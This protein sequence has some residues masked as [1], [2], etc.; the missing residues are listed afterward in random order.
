MLPP[1]RRSMAR[2]RA[3]GTAPP[4]RAAL[5]IGTW[6]Y[7]PDLGT[8]Q[9]GGV[10]HHLEP[11]QAEV[12]SFL[13]AEPGAMRSKTEIMDAVWGDVCV[14]EEVLTNAVYQLRRSLGDSARNPEFIETIAKKGYRLIA[15]VAPAPAV[16]ERLP[17][18]RRSSI[19]A[20]A[21]IVLGLVVWAIV[22]SGSGWVRQAPGAPDDV[23]RRC[24]DADLADCERVALANPGSGAAWSALAAARWAA[25]ARGEVGAEIG[26]PLV[27]DAATR[28]LALDASLSPPWTHLGLV[29]T[30]RW[31]WRAAEAAFIRAIELDPRSARAHGHY[32]EFLLL[33]GRTADAKRQLGQA[34][35]L[36]PQSKTVLHTAG[37]IHSMLRDVPAATRAYRTVLR[38]DPADGHA[39]TQLEKLSGRGRVPSGGELTAV[40]I[41]ALLKKRPLRPAV[42]AGMFAG[43]GEYEKALEWLRRARDEKDLSLLLVRLDDRWRGLHG[44]ERFRSILNATGL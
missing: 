38:L 34:L 32:A 11:K 19:A 25:V 31:E 12:L 41:D 1:H 2:S 40:E 44:D 8:L 3:G 37:F 29:R 7:L 24:Q 27:E 39:R 10:V 17:F 28:A 22:A 20:G 35:T 23:S 18:R 21:S 13:A 16:P 33:T 14:T 36:E 4:G 5:R 9:R 42:I 26:L 6:T 15:A 30:S 43:A